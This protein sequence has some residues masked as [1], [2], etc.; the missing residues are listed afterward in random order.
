MRS[1]FHIPSFA[2]TGIAERMRSTSFALLGLTAATGLAMV[3]ILSQPG[4]PL[5]SPAPLP[6][7]PAV[8]QSLGEAVSLQG[9]SGASVGVGGGA[10]APRSERPNGVAGG[11]G[12]SPGHR[13]AD[14]VE[15]APGAS[16]PV[17]SPGT[18]EAGGRETASP[19]NGPSPPPTEAAANDPAPGSPPVSSPPPAASQPEAPAGPGRSD[20]AAAAEHA[21]ERGIEASSGNAGGSSSETGN[22]NGEAK[23]HD[24]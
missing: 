17:A 16:L 14:P 19:G 1:S 13:S 23:G 12:S 4:W 11:G 9:G 5:L 20:S 2:G 3:A 15:V 6:S 21:S 8:E 7:G 10:A 22:G 18:G 24:E